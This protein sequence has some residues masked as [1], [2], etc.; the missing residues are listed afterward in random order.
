[1]NS[2]KKGNK[3]ELELLDIFRR[4]GYRANRNDQRYVGGVDRPDISLT[5]NGIRYHVEVKR[6]ERLRLHEAMEQA[7]HDSN[8]HAVPV[9]VHRRNRDA[10]LITMR[11][12]DFMQ[13]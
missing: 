7:V 1:M 9:V 4:H 8:G 2:K 3:G 13:R 10:W 12:D 5:M 6:T 11:L